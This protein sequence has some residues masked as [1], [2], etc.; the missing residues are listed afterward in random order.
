MSRAKII[1]QMQPIEQAIAALQANTQKKG[2]V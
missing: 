1:V 2:Q